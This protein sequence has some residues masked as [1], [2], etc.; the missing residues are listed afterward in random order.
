M[1]RIGLCAVVLVCFSNFASAAGPNGD[2][3]ILASNG[4]CWTSD[5]NHPAAKR[6][7]ERGRK[8]CPL[9][10]VAITPNDEWI[11]LVGGNEFYNSDELHVSR[12][13]AELWKNPNVKEYK[14]VAFTPQG[15]WVALVDSN[16]YY[17]EHIPED[18]EK[19]LAELA[20]AGVEIRSIAFTP[21]GGWVIL[22]GD[23][24][25]WYRGIPESAAKKLDE[26]VGEKTRVLCTAFN[27][28]NDWVILTAGNGI[29]ASNVNLPVAKV[30]HRLQKL[31]VALKWVAFSP[32][33]Y[34]G[35]YMIV[36]Q[37]TDHVK[38]TLT[39]TLTDPDEK[40]E[41]W[42]VYGPVAPR[43]AGQDETKTTLSHNAK[44][45]KEFSPLKRELLFARIADAPKGIAPVLS[46]EA[47]LY[48]RKLCPRGAGVAAVPDLSPEDFKNY[49]RSSENVDFDTKLFQAW[50]DHTNLR[51][52]KHER[53]I[54]FARRAYHFIRHNFVYEFP[55][56]D[57]HATSV[58]ERG[59]S[60][61]GGL[62]C[63]MVAT[64]R[65]NGIPARVLL[66]RWAQSGAPPDKITGE[67]YGQ[68]HVKAEFFAK[69]VGWVPLDMAAAVTDKDRGEFAHFGNDPGDFITLC[70]NQDIEVDTFIHGRFTGFGFQGVWWWE[71]GGGDVK[72]KEVWNVTKQPAKKK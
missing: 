59:T 45:L 54:S 6:L 65:A 60:D 26:L 64:L 34:P 43:F 51:R 39:T 14:C 1:K 44:V 42:Y 58:A 27:S 9:N 21:Q 31:R 25:V 61:C 56:G 7:I 19:K 48:S 69:G 15:G 12:K 71:K 53:D 36:R 63:V 29:W 8:G 67:I 17:A 47:T 30:L 3:F 35:D 66:G 4:G 32:G 41:E 49:T 70:A 11:T 72:P 18:A 5:I 55:G 40:V 2:W 62:S 28:Q 13:L 52:R 37:P 22:E 10:C 16:T 68:W 46:I 38:A 24:G 33:E 50:L 57:G 20:K 23:C